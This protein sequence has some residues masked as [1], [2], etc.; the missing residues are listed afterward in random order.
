MMI[1]MNLTDM[2]FLQVAA[3]A[4][5]VEYNDWIDTE[6]EKGDM[7][8]VAILRESR[9]RYRWISRNLEAYIAEENENG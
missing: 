6:I 3:A 4:K 1:E 5:V 2:V 9:N 7:D 8:R